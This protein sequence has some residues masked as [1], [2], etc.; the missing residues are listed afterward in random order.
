M[1]AS[2]CEYR[3]LWSMLLFDTVIVIH[4]LPERPGQTINF[5]KAKIKSLYLNGIAKKLF[6]T[7]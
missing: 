7:L 6:K 3:Y 2:Y 4:A 1:R 5:I